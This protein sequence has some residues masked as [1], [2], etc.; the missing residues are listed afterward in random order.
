MADINLGLVSA[1]NLADIEAYPVIISTRSNGIPNIIHP[2]ITDFNA[3]IVSAK[4]DGKDY[5]LDASDKNLPFDCYPSD[6][7]MTEVGLSIRK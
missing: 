2:V 3:V 4:I 7:S 5:L 6:R 1:L